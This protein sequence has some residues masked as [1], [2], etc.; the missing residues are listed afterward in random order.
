MLGTVSLAKSSQA[1]MNEPKIIIPLNV[2]SIK[3][4]LSS[5]LYAHRLVYISSLIREAFFCR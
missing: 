2:C 4:S 1:P 3:L 5:Y